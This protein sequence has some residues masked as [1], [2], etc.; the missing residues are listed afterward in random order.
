MNQWIRDSW[1]GVDE[2]PIDE[3]LRL[4]EVLGELTKMFIAIHDV[5]EEKFLDGLREWKTL[6]N[7]L[8][9]QLVERDAD[10]EL[11]IEGEDT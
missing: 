2:H 6:Q 4:A 3:G 5:Y 11:S 8:C 1:K 7:D 10:D 9:P